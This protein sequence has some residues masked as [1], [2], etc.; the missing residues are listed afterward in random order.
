MTKAEF[1]NTLGNPDGFK[2]AGDYEV[3]T[4]TH[5]LVTRLGLGQS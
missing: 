2:Q 1:V 3:L 5:R 4:Y